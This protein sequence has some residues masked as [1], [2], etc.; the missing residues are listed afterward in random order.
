[1]AKYSQRAKCYIRCVYAKSRRRNNSAVNAAVSTNVVRRRRRHTDAISHI[2][3]QRAAILL[4]AVVA[5]RTF[6]AHRRSRPL[7]YAEPLA[8]CR[9]PQ[10]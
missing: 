3:D 10:Q 7:L 2:V 4:S 8:Q 5:K 9:K 1:M 6:Y